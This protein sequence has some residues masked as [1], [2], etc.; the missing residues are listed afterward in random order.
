MISSPEQIRNKFDMLRQAY[1]S[2]LGSKIDEIDG[3]WQE[4]LQGN[5]H[6]DNCFTMQSLAHKLAGSGATF[7]FHALSEY[8]KIL[9]LSLQEVNHKNQN[10]TLNQKQEITE[11]LR[12]IK[13]ATKQPDSEQAMSRQR[14]IITQKLRPHLTSATQEHNKLVY[15]IEDD[16]ELAQELALQISY[17]GYEIHIFEHLDGL[18]EEINK[19]HPE[20]I[21]M[22]II[23]PEGNLA[24]IELIEAARKNWTKNIP[25]LFMSARG[26]F[27]ARLKAV[28][29]GGESYFTK[30]VDL[31]SLIE[32]LDNLT[33]TYQPEPYRILLVEDDE[34]L[35]EYHALHL[36][37]RGMITT[38]VTNPLE[39]MQPLID[40][41]PD[42]ILM[43]MYM[44]GCSGLELASVI[45]QQD[46]FVSIPIVFL[47]VETDLDK[48]LTAMSLG[49][50]EFLT[51][52]IEPDYLVAEITSRVQRSRI[53]RSFMVR[54]SLTGLLNHTNTK[55]QL[56]SEV[57]R[58]RRYQTHLS[59]AM[60][61]ID[62][63]KSVND[64]YGHLTGDRVIRSLARLLQQRLRKSDVIGRYGG[65]EFAVILP[66]TDGGTAVKILN[67]IREGFAQVRQQS[68]N[69]EFVVTFSVGIACFPNYQDVQSLSDAA[70]KALYQAKRSGRNRAVLSFEGSW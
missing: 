5:D 10:L 39:I 6:N 67:D 44:P 54:D 47:S 4:V 56:A 7:G 61:D 63:F 40:F 23:F 51:K 66:H 35:G 53:L 27:D 25:V 32:K 12:E 14:L 20:V 31:G 49:G 11:L 65:E 64:T 46:A 59:F 19:N 38:L 29:A 30:P 55:E 17:F 9:E 1:A 37:Q 16:L 24:G 68:G 45:R 36:E 43:D 21:I 41:T 60:I 13:H 48:H 42:L 57:A 26:D 22:D 50:D 18:T 28:R 2:Q 62:K 34:I 52:P 58:A 70:D 69:H 3:L 33:A 15:L 8:A